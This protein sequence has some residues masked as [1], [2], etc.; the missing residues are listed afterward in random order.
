MVW[1]IQERK[2]ILRKTIRIIYKYELSFSKNIQNEMPK[3]YPVD[4]LMEVR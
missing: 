1:R 4:N 3:A 2:V